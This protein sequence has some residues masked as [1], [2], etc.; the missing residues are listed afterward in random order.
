M[1]DDFAICPN[2]GDYNADFWLCDEEGNILDD[3]K[4]CAD[5]VFYR[6]CKNCGSIVSTKE[7]CWQHV[8]Y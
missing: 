1:T 5:N 7:I 2:C 3:D 6:K 8:E 4:Y